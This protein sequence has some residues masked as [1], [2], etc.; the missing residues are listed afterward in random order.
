MK[1]IFLLEIWAAILAFQV[2][3]KIITKIS[4]STEAEWAA[5]LKTIYCTVKYI[6]MDMWKLSGLIS[7][8]CPRKALTLTV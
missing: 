6:K 1:F 2:I 5:Q 4:T 8:K 7:D 3:T